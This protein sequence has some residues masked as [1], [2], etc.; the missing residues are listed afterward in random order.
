LRER[1]VLRQLEYDNRLNG[2]IFGDVALPQLQKPV[3]IMSRDYAKKNEYSFSYSS[4][5]H[6]P[7]KNTQIMK[8]GMI[9]DM[10]SIHSR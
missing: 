9:H 4:E 6:S 7:L 8:V 2:D 5:S 3:L 10:N 1:K